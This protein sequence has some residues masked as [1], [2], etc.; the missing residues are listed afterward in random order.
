[1]PRD[2]DANYS[3]PPEEMDEEDEAGPSTRAQK[4]ATGVCLLARFLT[5]TC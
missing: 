4:R 3:P 2:A 1:M 5:L